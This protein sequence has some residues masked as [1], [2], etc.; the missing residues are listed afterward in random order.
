MQSNLYKI[1]IY[2]D[3]VL[4]CL[5]PFLETVIFDAVMHR[6]RVI[7]LATLDC[8]RVGAVFN[9]ALVEFAEVPV[10]VMPPPVP[11]RP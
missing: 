1:A 5:F 11:A 7:D 8:E 10:H 3:I 4:D 2:P 9:R 6:L